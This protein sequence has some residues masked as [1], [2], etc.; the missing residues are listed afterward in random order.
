M[1]D[2]EKL[3]R[4]VEAQPVARA[5][6]SAVNAIGYPFVSR[7]AVL[8]AIDRAALSGSTAPLDRDG[9]V[10]AAAEAVV[11]AWREPMSNYW[12]AGTDGH[13]ATIRH[14]GPRIDALQLA[15]RDL[16]AASPDPAQGG[17]T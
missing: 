14:I 12:H 1:S 5:R 17:E 16:A 15:L 13:S 8:A 2:W 4:E 3:R 11:S 9:A 6:D 10:V 7:A